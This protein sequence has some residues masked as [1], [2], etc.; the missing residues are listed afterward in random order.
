MMKLYP[1][2]PKLKGFDNLSIA[3]LESMG[4]LLFAEL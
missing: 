4:L 3:R 2:Y 1:Y